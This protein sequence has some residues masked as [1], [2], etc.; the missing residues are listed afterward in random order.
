MVT[1][2][3][4]ISSKC[5]WARS[6]SFRL[7]P[8]NEDFRSHFTSACSAGRG[9][10]TPSATS[11]AMSFAES[12]FFPIPVDVMLAPMC[13][14]DRSKAW[15]FAP[16]RRFSRCWAALRATRSASGLLKS[17]SRGCAIRTTGL[18]T[19]KPCLVGSVRCL[20]HLCRRFFADPLQSIHDCCRCRG[21]EPA[22]VY[23][24]LRSSAAA[25]VFSGSRVDRVGWRPPR[26]HAAEIRRA[27]RL[28]RRR[29]GLAV[30]AWF[31]V[32]G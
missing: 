8:R 17:S 28:G 2:E 4:T 25:R 21:V 13:L 22:A 3:A 5:R 16:S 7:I 27:H 9:T 26:R 19:N 12:S 1:R 14:A 23:S 15:R 20:G 10:A 6:V 11:A 30:I 31:M 24:W 18:P 29:Y 32:R